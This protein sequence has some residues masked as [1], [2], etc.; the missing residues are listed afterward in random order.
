MA[1]SGDHVMV[2]TDASIIYLVHGDGTFISFN[3]LTGQHRNVCYIGRCYYAATPTG[4]WIVKDVERKGRSTTFGDGRFLRLN[5]ADGT[6]GDDGQGRTAYGIHSHAQFTQM[7]D[8]KI[9]KKGFDKEGKGYRSYGCILLSEDDLSLVEASFNANG[10]QIAVETGPDL[11][12][13]PA[14]QGIAAIPSWLGI[15]W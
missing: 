1:E 3:G 5:D 12:P 11:A 4:S 13:P 6:G 9:E 15:Q 10:G 8:D 14:P 2:D 7:L